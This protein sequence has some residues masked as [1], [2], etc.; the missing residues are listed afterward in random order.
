MVV[1]VFIPTKKSYSYSR[2]YEKNE[3]VRHVQRKLQ[4]KIQDNTYP[5]ESLY[6]VITSYY[7]QQMCSVP[8]MLTFLTPR[9]P[10]NDCWIEHYNK[11]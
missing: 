3:K 5:F 10:I 4:R 1:N 8:Q 6:T 9:A 7:L 2:A 11:R